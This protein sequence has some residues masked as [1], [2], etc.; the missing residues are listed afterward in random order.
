[1]ERVNVFPSTVTSAATKMIFT[2]LREKCW[3]QTATAAEANHEYC[4]AVPAYSVSYGKM[5]NFQ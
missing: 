1:M 3:T 4:A 5:D 2:S